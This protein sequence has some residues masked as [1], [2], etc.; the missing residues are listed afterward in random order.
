MKATLFSPGPAR[1]HYAFWE[2]LDVRNLVK[3]HSAHI[4]RTVTRVGDSVKRIASTRCGGVREQRCL[5]LVKH[6]E[7]HRNE[8]RLRK[9]IVLVLGGL[10][11]Y[12]EYC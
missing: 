9:G 10:N 3:T 11:W 12:L 5:S 1:D 7:E 4:E 2:C 8:I 6:P